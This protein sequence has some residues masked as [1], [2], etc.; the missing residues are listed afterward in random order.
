VVCGGPA[1]PSEANKKQKGR[2]EMLTAIVR[3]GD[4]SSKNALQV[5]TTGQIIL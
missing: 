1:V 3:E 4:F 2:F 5:S